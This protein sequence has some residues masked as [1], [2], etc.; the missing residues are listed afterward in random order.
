M[1]LRSSILAVVAAL[2]CSAVPS[3]AQDK[4]EPPPQ[5]PPPILNKHELL[6][7]YVWST[8][9]PTGMLHATFASGFEHW[10]DAPE[11]WSQG[12]RGY[13]ARWFSEYAESAIGNTSKYAVARLLHQ[14]PT[15]VPC[16]CTGARARLLHAIAAPFMARAMEDGAWVFS[17]AQ[18]AGLTAE[19]VI[20]AATWYPAPHGVRDGALHAVSGIASKMATDVLKEFV[21]ER[22]RRITKP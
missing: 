8:I 18:L 6:K 16:Q 4:P 9:G 13:A 20:P 22:L 7:K 17:P 11:A 19:N 1:S 21:P 15:Y 3:L 10:R 5:P 12:E 2:L 14:D